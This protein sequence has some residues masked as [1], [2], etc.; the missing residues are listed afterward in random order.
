MLRE[1]R[2]TAVAGART[3]CSEIPAS[4]MYLGTCMACVLTASSLALPSS[5]SAGGA[6]AVS[7]DPP[8]AAFKAMIFA[9]SS[10]LDIFFPTTAGDFDRSKGGKTSARE[11]RSEK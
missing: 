8:A 5:I 9:T 2:N 7:A 6:G 4:Q 3:T 1:D 11:V 10:A